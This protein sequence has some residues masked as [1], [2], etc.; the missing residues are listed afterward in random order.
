MTRVDVKPGQDIAAAIRAFKKKCAKDGVI[1]DYKRSRRFEKPSDRR[2]KEFRESVKR[3]R[4]AA[5]R[6]GNR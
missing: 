3:T 2:R 6:S 5:L 1:K 4:L